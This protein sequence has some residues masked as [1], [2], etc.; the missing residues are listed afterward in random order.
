MKV[1]EGDGALAFQAANAH[2]RIERGERNRHVRRMNGDAAF[3]RAE[4]GVDAVLAFERGAA[5]AGL[6]LVAGGERGVVKVMAA[7][8]LQ[9]VAA[10]RGHVAQLRRGAGEERLGKQRIARTHER[11]ACRRAVADH[12]ADAQA[13]FWQLANLGERQPRD[14]DEMRG[15]LDAALHEIEE[16]GA[17]AEEAA[18]RTRRFAQRRLDVARLDVGK[19]I[20]ASPAA[21]FTAATI[22][23]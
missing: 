9:E 8:S 19:R 11:M 22:L 1:G 7:R 16:I 15:A 14:V 17:C 18:A 6:A 2:G 13:A 10:H 20:H 3:A 4:N 12:G 23:G 21:F 5:R